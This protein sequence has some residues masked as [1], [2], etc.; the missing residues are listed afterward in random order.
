[1][2]G[3]EKG[4]CR[5]LHGDMSMRGRFWGWATVAWACW[6]G[7]AIAEDF[8]TD[9]D[10]TCR[11][12]RVQVRAADPGSL[13]ELLASED[14]GGPWETVLQ[15]T[16]ATDHAWHDPVSRSE[17]RR[18]Y[19]WQRTTPRPPAAPIWN[20]R[21]T[22]HAGASHE[23]LREGDARVVVLGFTDNAG[24][25]TLAGELKPVMDRM[26]GKP[27]R[28][29]LVNP[30][31]GRGAVAAAVAAAGLSTP[32]LLDPAQVV[33]R[34]FQGLR[35][36]EVVA[37]TPEMM[38]EVYRG[39]VADRVEV[40]GTALRQEF[41]GDA[42]EAY[43]GGKVVRYPQTRSAGR[44]LALVGLKVPDYETWVAPVLQRAC[45]TCHRPGDIGS[46]AMTNHAVVAARAASMK[47]NLLEGLM[48]PWHADAPKGVF[49][50]DFSLEPGEVARL[51]AW[52]DAGAPRG[53]GEDPLM[54]KAPAAPADWP[55]GKPDRILTIPR[56]SIPAKSSQAEVPYQYTF[57][58]SPF[59]TNVW[60]RAAVVRPGNRAVVHHALVFTATS[61]AD[62]LQV[63]GGLGGFF[64]GYVPGMEQA[65]YPEGTG[66]LL[67]RGSYIVFQMHYTPVGTAQTDETQI[68]LYL[69]AT[70]P[71]RELK[72]GAA[73]DTS[74]VIPP[75][76]RDAAVTAQTTFAR[77]VT[78]YEMSP[79][80]HYRGK[81]MRFEAV[82][83]DGTVDT[84]LNV[85]HYDFAWQSMYRFSE[86]RRYPA[87]TTLRLVG[88]FDNSGANPWNP[89]PASEV[90]FGEQTDEEMFI[91]YMNYTE[92]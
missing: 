74:F 45:V 68:G 65:W 28:F 84:L 1:M 18:F 33:T 80:M 81:R 7:V 64:A 5:V 20:F 38:E 73:Y 32:V 24:L 21:L 12:P 66:K 2:A 8:G 14:P 23:L 31:E 52:L 44:E 51:V 55:L 57:V 72:T 27:V 37:V 61:F 87:G 92:E 89:N 49:T 59:S 62:L 46:F 13:Y 39:G 91:G 78:V 41:L 70:P 69:S 17:H 11:L 29:W 42:V 35:V 25:A 67:K 4:R 16:G 83:P 90:R 3:V 53:A 9:L 75:G 36:G 82:L 54:A 40:N 58:A 34:T 63:Q 30:V 19:R 76:A 71:A 50:N 43:L 10:P 88:G 6:A 60:L 79:H 26:Q 48:P 15:A 56:Q 22:D 77:P 85:P 86:P 47:A